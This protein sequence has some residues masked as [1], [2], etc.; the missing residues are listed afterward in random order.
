MRIVLYI[1]EKEFKQI[2]RNKAMLPI[3]FVMPMI[4]LLVLSFAVDYEIKNIKLNVV[5]HDHSQFSRMLINKFARSPYFNLDIY[6]NTDEEARYHIEKGYSDL[7]L[8]IEQDFEKKLIREGK[9][10]IQVLLNA[11]EIVGKL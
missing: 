11:I 5:D 3:I 1:L 7:S 4:Q 2:F 9:A 10:D 6:A 8:I